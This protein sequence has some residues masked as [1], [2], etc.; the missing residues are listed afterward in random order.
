MRR[1]VVTAQR[2]GPVDGR[3]GQVARKRLAAELAAGQAKLDRQR[4]AITATERGIAEL[5]Q[6]L[7]DLRG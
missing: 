4:K 6:K 5:T 1:G 3:N 2:A 7:E